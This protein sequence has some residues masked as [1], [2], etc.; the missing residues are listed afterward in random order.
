MNIDVEATDNERER[1][2][3]HEKL[4]FEIV[5]KGKAAEKKFSVVLGLGIFVRESFESF[6][7]THEVFFL[8]VLPALS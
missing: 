2:E 1:F 5:F 4:L 8:R 3:T 7:I 6:A